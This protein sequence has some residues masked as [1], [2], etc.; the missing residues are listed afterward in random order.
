MGQQNQ[1]LSTDNDAKEKQ[2]HE[3]EIHTQLE[4]LEKSLRHYQQNNFHMRE[5]IA[6]KGQEGD[7]KSM[8]KDCQQL[9]TD[10]NKLTIQVYTLGQVH[11]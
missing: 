10:L 6:M 4:V 8:A 1:L 9:L 5:F 3:N 2:L 7:Y 11:L